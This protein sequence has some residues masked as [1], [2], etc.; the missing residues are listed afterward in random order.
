MNSKHVITA[1][2]ASAV[3]F[4]AQ[5]KASDEGADPA[6]QQHKKSQKAKKESAEQ[7]ELRELR[8]QMKQQ[9][10]EI[11]EL[12][13][14]LSGKSQQAQ[15]AQQAASD[16]QAQAAQAAAAAQQAS[17][18]AT[19]A[20]AKAEAA[21]TAAT[22]ATAKT[23]DLQ[24]QVV[25][26]QAQV[27]QEIH[28]PGTIH[29]KGVEITP[30]G[31]VAAEGVYR[32]HS[33]N[34]DINTPLNSIPLP[35]ASEGHTSELNFSGRQS[36]LSVLVQGDTGKFK[37]TGYYEMD[38]LGTGTSSNNNQSNSYVLRQRQIWGKVETPGGFGMSGGQM[39]SLVTEDRKGTDNRTEIQPQTIDPQYT[40]G[41]SWTR[42][43]GFRVQKRFGNYN[44]GAFTMALAEEQAQITSFTANG[45]NPTDYFFGGIG[46]NGGLY[47]A[48]GNI[49]A[50]NTAGTAGITTYAN[51]VVPDTIVKFAY[52][53][54]TF[55]IEVGGLARWFRDYYLPVTTTYTTPGTP[56][57]TYGTIYQN[58][59]STGGG[60]FG[61]ARVYLGKITE[62]GVQAMAGA[63]VGRYGS[64]QLADVTLRP[65]ETLE[66]V[67]NYHGLFSLENHLNPH[68]DVFA[69]YGGEYAQRTVYT[70][71]AGNL[72][73][74]GPANLSNAGCYNLPAAVSTGSGG[75]GSISASTCGSPTRYIQEAM[76]GF[77]WKPINS[78]KY[79]RLQY[80]AT[81]SYIQR[82][83]WSGVGSATTPSGPRATEPMV[84]VQMRYYIP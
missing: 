14:M 62:V 29:Y 65:D 12:K 56:I 10:S 54:P 5:A 48:A 57:Y 50:G 64:A 30:G 28:E 75:G 35:S 46:Q 18:A 61:A 22:A 37:L 52:D 49:G 55:H 1:V 69:Y 2:L 32:Q 38:W 45:T 73:G 26:N 4:T 79:G 7:T 25:G 51:N 53:V 68:W 39:W 3:M 59:T 81:Y 15:S 36:R 84:H 24:E 66:P 60:V 41:Y 80:S 19:D 43:P 27:Q 33:V 23:A 20:S 34:S 40:V 17:Q 78:P 67:R 21:T 77:T 6:P 58:H 31:F 9:Q 63:G 70:T 47:N 11:E 13:G 83:L 44:T 8:E 74:Y 82:N 16:A 71:P 76:G 72:I 42:Q